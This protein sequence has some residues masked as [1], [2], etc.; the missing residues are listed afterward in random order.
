MKSNRD[1]I[2]E[3]CRTYLKVKD[4][5]DNCVNGLQVEGA[6]AVRR[7]VAG[8]SLSE[9]LIRVAIDR[10]AQMVLVH[11]GFFPNFWGKPPAI[12]GIVRGRLKLLLSHDINLCGF[13]L[14]L[15]AHPEVGNN[16]SLCRLFGIRRTVPVDIGFAG[17]LAKP[18]DRDAWVRIV[19]KKLGTRCFVVPGGPRRVRR[20]CVIS[21]GSSSWYPH[22][23]LAGADTFL[24]GDIGEWVVRAVEELGLNLVSAGHYNTEKLGVQNLGR[25]IAR[26][27]RVP[28]EFVDVPCEA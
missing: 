21:G 3:Y 19:E 8:V 12:D 26:R 17:D 1:A 6:P 14:P 16:I 9:R 24:C 13:H 7:I 10:D 23:V 18:C 2:V 5:E 28:V 15:D 27:F 11:H 25:R 22:A 4:F 20:V